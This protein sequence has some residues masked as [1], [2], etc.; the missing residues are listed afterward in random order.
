MFLAF[1]LFLAIQEPATDLGTTIVTARKIEEAIEDVPASVSALSSD[2]ITKS[3]MR[4]ISDA[5]GRIPNL[6]FTEFSAR[7]L[8]FPYVRGI[9]SGLG[10]PSVATY[11][12]GVPQLSVGSTNL[13]LL[14]MERIEFLRG[15]QGTLYGRNAMG[16]VI[17][18]VGRQPDGQTEIGGSVMR[19]SHS[20]Q[21]VSS[22]YSGPLGDSAGFVFDGRV[23]RR[24]GYT[25]NDFTGELVDDRMAFS[26]RTQLAL[27]LDDSSSLRF[28]LTGQKAEDG[29][30]GLGELGSLRDNPHRIN[31][32][33]EGETSRASLQPSVVYAWAEGGRSFTSIS[34]LTTMD[35]TE[36]SDFDFSSIDGL[37]RRTEEEQDVFYQ[38]LR[39]SDERGFDVD[40]GEGMRLLVG[41][42]G[43]D[44]DATRS[45]ANDFR[46]GMFPPGMQGIDTNTGD[47][48]NRGHSLFGQLGI[49]PAPDWEL[50]YGV[51]M[52]R[53]SKK[54]DANHT[55]ETGGFT[56]LDTDAS[57]EDEFSETTPMLSASYRPTDSSQVYAYAAKAFKAGGFNLT[58]PAG[59]EFFDPE[60]SWTY[61]VGY[62]RSLSERVLDLKLAA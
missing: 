17:H 31:Q 4:S 40:K 59:E 37:R 14:G 50:T 33:F 6:H 34:A 26:G 29:G 46:P 7:R 52:D 5:V 38:E 1:T 11:V 62:K 22:F 42:S 53:E 57:F 54:L 27:D 13:P 16:G 15:P 19:G 36:T 44:S 10:E 30:F 8:S 56:V 24:D 49:S 2:D 51:R 32:D 3:G 45:A 55:F 23:S 28:S 18:M 9:G 58:A 47:F 21:E 35:V 25:T 20:L 12:D 39:W 41:L 61:E 43:F 60:S 48:T